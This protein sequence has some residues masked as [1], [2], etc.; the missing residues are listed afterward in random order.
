MKVNKET[1]QHYT[2]GGNCDGW[3]LLESDTLSVIE[4]SI[5]P[6]SGEQL[7][8]HVRAQQLFFVLEGVAWFES[9]GLET[10]VGRG[11]G[12][13]VAAGVPHRIRNQSS[14]VLHILVISEPKSHGDRVNL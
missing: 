5:P 10:V 14:S 7:H 6:G 8:Y 4:E 1:A 2:W 12:F 11:E 9:D 3:H 13:K